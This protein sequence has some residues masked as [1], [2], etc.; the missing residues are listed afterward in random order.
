MQPIR[1]SGQGNALLAVRNV[2]TTRTM[3]EM[4]RLRKATRTAQA[5]AI[6]RT[7]GVLPL[8]IQFSSCPRSRWI[9]CRSGLRLKE[10]GRPATWA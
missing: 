6:E 7:S 8:H 3:L 4:L 5:L 10:F 2:Q 1:N 9:S